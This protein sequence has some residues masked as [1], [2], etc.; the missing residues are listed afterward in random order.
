MHWM[1][2]MMYPVPESVSFH[3]LDDVASLRYGVDKLSQQTRLQLPIS[4]RLHLVCIEIIN[5]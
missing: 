3:A 4:T 1:M 5:K 2:M